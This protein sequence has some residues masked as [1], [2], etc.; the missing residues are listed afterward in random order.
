M[1]EKE[2]QEVV[3]WSK[4]FEFKAQNVKDQHFIRDV[5]EEKFDHEATSEEVR[6]FFQDLTSRIDLKKEITN[7]FCEFEKMREW[8]FAFP[9]NKT[10]DCCIIKK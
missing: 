3:Q 5:L 4:S 9:V 8:D 7:A 1:T 2:K 10:E 6:E